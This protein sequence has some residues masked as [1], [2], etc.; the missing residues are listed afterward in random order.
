MFGVRVTLM[1]THD[2]PRARRALAAL[3]ATVALAAVFTGAT[4]AKESVTN[5]SEAAVAATTTAKLTVPKG[6]KLKFNKGFA[7]TKLNTKV[8]ATCYWYVKPGKG[9]TNFS[10]KNG[11]KQWYLPSQDQVKDGELHLVSKR[12][13]TEGTNAKGKP[14]K[15]YCRS[16]MVT[17]APSFNFEYGFV[18]FTVNVPYRN[19]LWSALWLAASNH[20]WPPELD[21]LEHWNSQNNSGMY[22]HA[23]NGTTQGGR[24]TLH[25][26]LSKGW[27]TITLYW[28]KTRLTWYYDGRVMF[29]TTKNIPHQKMYIIMN[30][31]D[32]SS[33]VGWCNGA[34][35]VKTVKV[36][37]P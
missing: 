37:Q 25:S 9:C 16:G 23:A 6:W 17:T 35:L 27:H 33:A 31:A 2:I 29:T 3:S 30:V 18:Q 26:N 4:V 13:V 14:E 5:K 36:W 20:K 12:E 22:L 34:M 1:P 24:L 32:V 11:E 10:S 15:Y 21:I 8:W 7:G 19:G 28:T